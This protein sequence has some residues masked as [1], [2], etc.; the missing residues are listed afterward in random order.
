MGTSRARLVLP[1][2]AA[3][4]VLVLAGCGSSATGTTSQT[5]TPTAAG[6]S[7]VTIKDFA[8]S[9]QTLTVKP[10]TTVT[11]TNK[12]STPHTVT[13]TDGPSTSAETTGL[14]DSGSLSQGDTFSFTFAKSG[15][16]FY[17]C[18]LHF[19]MQSMHAKVVVSG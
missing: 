19:T 5:S 13:A 9:P 8:F 15:T 7:S 12:D 11:W 16:Y 2:A 18:T 10:G 4:A 17:A 6:G 1:V 3:L 14:F